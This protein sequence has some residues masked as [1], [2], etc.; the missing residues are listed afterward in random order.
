MDVK[1]ASAKVYIRPSASG[2][3]IS[4]LLVSQIIEPADGGW[5]VTDPAEAS[6]MM[7][8]KSEK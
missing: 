8:R 5:V 3:L 7:I 6:A 4:E 2:K 1:E